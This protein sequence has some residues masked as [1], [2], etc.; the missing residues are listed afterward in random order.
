VAYPAKVLGEDEVVHLHLR[1]H[2]KALLLPCVALVAVFG[3]L[4][5]GLATVSGAR[6]PWL[7]AEVL[8]ALSLGLLAFLSLVPYLRWRS[9]HLVVTDRR[10]LTRSGIVRREVQEVPLER[11]EDVAVGRRVRE[12]PFGC[13][14]L[15][16]SGGEEH[17][18]VVVP[19]VPGV[20]AVGRTVSDLAGLPPD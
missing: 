20:R 13:G 3:F 19:A 5:F 4:G 7:S 15:V 2:R 18:Q 10:V 17:G 12:R 9:T 14:T 11:V 8:L 1:P 16:V 6:S